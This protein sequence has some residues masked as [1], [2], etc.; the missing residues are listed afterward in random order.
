[1]FVYVCCAVLVLILVLLVA[2]GWIRTAETF[3][4]NKSPIFIDPDTIDNKSPLHN[5]QNL[6]DTVTWIR[7][8]SYMFVGKTVFISWIW[9]NKKFTNNNRRMFAYYDLNTKYMKFPYEANDYKVVLDIHKKGDVTKYD[10]AIMYNDEVD[11]KTNYIF[12]HNDAFIHKK[13]DLF[14]YYLFVIV[15]IYDQTRAFKYIHP[16]YTNIAGLRMSSV[17]NFAVR[18]K[19][20]LLADL[21]IKEAAQP[22]Y[23]HGKQCIDLRNSVSIITYQIFSVDIVFKNNEPR[24][25]YVNRLSKQDKKYNDMMTQ[26]EKII[27]KTFN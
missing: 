8:H 24:V 2:A 18:A 7:N 15:D 14:T 17:D 3:D 21:I 20:S 13:T 10:P 1:M 12:I 19:L 23:F 6:I 16:T 9:N 4:V 27:N 26:L 5:N 25:L 11:N 22:P